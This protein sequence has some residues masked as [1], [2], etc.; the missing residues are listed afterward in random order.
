[1]GIGL[2]RP[3]ESIMLIGSPIVMLDDKH[4]NT[5]RSNTED[6]FENKIKYTENL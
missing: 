4:E 5:I 3:K 2:P 6:V 1:M